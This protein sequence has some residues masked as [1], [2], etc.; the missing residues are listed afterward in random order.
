MSVVNEHKLLIDGRWETGKEVRETR[1]PYDGSMVGR[2]HFADAHQVKKAVDA[3]QEAFGKTGGLSSYEKARALE[4]VSGQIE[5]Y[6]KLRHKLECVVVVIEKR[7][8][9]EYRRGEMFGD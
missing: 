8:T 3:A 5:T 7:R 4:Y 1:S 6:P 9:E 2:V